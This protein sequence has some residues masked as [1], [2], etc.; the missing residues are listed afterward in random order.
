MKNVYLKY[1]C[2]LLFAFNGYSQGSDV[3]FWV[4]NSGSISD[5]EYTQMSQS[6]QAIMT[7]VLECNP[8]N[9]ISVVQYG[10]TGGSTN[11]KI[12]VESGF[13][14]ATY[15]FP[16]RSTIVG[17]SDF[18]HESLGLI[19]NAIDGVANPNIFGTTTLTRTPGNG[20][21]IYFFTDALRD[22]TSGS[23]IVNASATG[24]GTNAAF[25]NYTSFKTV[26]G[27]IFVVTLI[28]TNVA[29]IQASAAVA[30]TGGTYMGAVESY[31]ADP[32]GA[33]TTPRFFLNKTTFLLTAAEIANTIED[34]CS[35]A[36]DPCVA[37]LILVSPTHDVAA[38]I[39]DNR[40]ASNSIT[41]SNVI[42]NTAVGVYHA[43]N[44]IV[45]KPG[46]HGVNGSR[47]RGYIQDCPSDFVGR[48][49]SEDTVNNIDKEEENIS[50]FPNPSSHLVTIALNQSLIQHI[51]ILSMDG[52]VMFDK[53][54]GKVEK[55]EVAINYYKEGV[56]LITV[57]TNNGKILKSKLVKN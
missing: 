33:G 6:V 21:V 10:S 25:Q 41:A 26:R 4:D 45:L 9:R 36:V 24:V 28:S 39:Q 22:T 48:V 1:L 19:G 17:N 31:P 14:N 29:A 5:T 47:F 35:V 57:L 23:C 49:V 30:S 38:L 32:D 52:R 50:V 18:A 51:S 2:F 55:Y 40:Q 7:S 12:Y 16:R 11:A 8:D 15:T 56:Y 13:V 54:I 37:D 3:I 34:I 44:T 46:F 43:K 27:A 20:L 53:E 42:N